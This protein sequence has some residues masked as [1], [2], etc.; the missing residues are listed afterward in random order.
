MKVVF[1]GDG[2]RV[3]TLGEGGAVR[4]WDIAGRRFIAELHDHDSAIQEMAFN[5]ESSCLVTASTN[6]TVQKWE[7][8]TGGN[9]SRASLPG[10]D[11]YP[12]ALSLD[13]SILATTSGN[14]TTTKLW[15]IDDNDGQLRPFATLAGHTDHI[16]TAAFRDSNFLATGSA[17]NT[18]RLWDLDT[19]Q[20]AHHLC[21]IVGAVSKEQWENS[22]PELPYKPI[23][24]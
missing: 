12:L 7:V 21:R 3:A 17:D 10:D 18:V 2:R 20:V 5:G 16:N 6:G 1:S 19:D 14:D 11:S 4:L 8:V 23:C 13:G 22:I 24:Q 9:V 15:N